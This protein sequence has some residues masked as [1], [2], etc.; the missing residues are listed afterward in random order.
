[1]ALEQEPPRRGRREDPP[2]E[3][4]APCDDREWDPSEERSYERE[5][6]DRF[7]LGGFED[8]WSS[9]VAGFADR[10]EE[11]EDGHFALS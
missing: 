11:G 8:A 2:C 4:H 6:N 7:D 9:A 5:W 3:D 1:M 10:G